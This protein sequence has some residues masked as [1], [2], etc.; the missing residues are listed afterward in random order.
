MSLI[1]LKYGFLIFLMANCKPPNKTFQTILPCTEK[2]AE[3][4]ADDFMMKKHYKLSEYT[5]T[6]VEKEDTIEIEYVLKDSLT[7]GGGA[8]IKL[9]KGNCKIV[10]IKRYQ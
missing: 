10:E 6:F 8:L 5:R 7:F 9:L 4:I 3:S 2:S 1:K